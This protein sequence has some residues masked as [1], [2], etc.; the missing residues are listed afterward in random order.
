MWHAHRVPAYVTKSNTIVSERFSED[1]Q[2]RMKT[3]P[4]VWKRIDRSVL[5]DNENA[6]L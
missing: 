4:V 3:V 5:G 2:K 1:N 6:Y